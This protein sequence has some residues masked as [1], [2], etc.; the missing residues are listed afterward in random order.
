MT[1]HSTFLIVA[2]M[3]YL[4]TA[5]F[6][7]RPSLLQRTIS[8]CLRSTKL[9]QDANDQIISSNEKDNLSPL[10]PTISSQFKILTCSSTSCAKRTKALGL[11]EYALFSGLYERKENANAFQLIV[12]ETSCLG[13]CK[14]GPCVG[15][16]H[17]DYYGTVAL[18]GMGPNEFSD[19]VFHK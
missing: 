12:E 14:L 15:I 11:D 5:F 17:E 13:C 10:D 9:N 16:E 8:S 19:R 3:P 1:L 2:L 4:S 7:Q 18:E 6:V